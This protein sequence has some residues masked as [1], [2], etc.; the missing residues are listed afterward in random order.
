M[1]DIDKNSLQVESL[2]FEEDFKSACPTL[3]IKFIV[4]KEKVEGTLKE[5][6]LEGKIWE[7]ETMK[8]VETSD[9]YVVSAS[10]V[11]QGMNWI[12]SEISSP[13]EMALKLTGYSL[14]P[15]DVSPSFLP[16]VLNC[17]TKKLILRNRLNF[18]EEYFESPGE[19]YYIY[20]NE[21]KIYCNT[22]K[23]LLSQ[24]IF[25]VTIPTGLSGSVS[26]LY[27]DDT[28]ESRSEG[29]P[30]P[31]RKYL[32]RDYLNFMITEKI[33]IKSPV[34]LAP[35]FSNCSLDLSISENRNWVCVYH[36]YNLMEDPL[37]HT[38]IFAQLD[39]K[40]IPNYIN[41]AK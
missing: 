36:K 10:A 33:E 6:S 4:N 13:S 24:G 3:I 7:V 27:I 9:S 19:A 35:L 28:A 26:S 21:N 11:P 41:E 29:V 31:Y 1:F 16:K 22:Y 12:L 5:L 2:I 39:F 25:T 15:G 17:S 30:P 32:Y 23:S 8:I 40:N 14:N 38:T 34:R 18:L 20:A 37:G